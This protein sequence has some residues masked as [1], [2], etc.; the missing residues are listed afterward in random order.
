MRESFG[1]TWTMQLMFGFTFL[2]VSFLAI[3]ISYS[4]A[5]RVR[6]E[7]ISIIEKYGGISDRSS[8]TIA[9]YVRS[10]G[11]RTQGRCNA[12]AGKLVYGITSDGDLQ[13]A[14]GGLYLGCIKKDKINNNAISNVIYEV[15]MF[16]KFNLPI[17][18]D[19]TTFVIKGKTTDLVDNV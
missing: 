16:Y 8:Q 14:N 1:S 15:T 10:S 18:G 11:Y 2:F 13:E 5:F 9:N 12:E 3:T 6:N 17:V 19:V 7:V 4:K